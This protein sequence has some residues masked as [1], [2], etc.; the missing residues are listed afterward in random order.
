LLA[1]SE[2]YEWARVRS[3]PASVGSSPEAVVR[4]VARGD[5]VEALA[6]AGRF[7]GRLPRDPAAATWRGAR[8]LA[9]CCAT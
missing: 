8:R 9:A 5:V 4:C 1:G 3:S 2:A 7:G 6:F